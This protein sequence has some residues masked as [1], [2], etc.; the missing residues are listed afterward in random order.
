MPFANIR[1]SK[2]SQVLHGW[3]IHLIPYEMT[4][5]EFFVKFVLTK[6]LSPECGINIAASEVI[7]R[8]KLSETPVSTATQISPKCGKSNRKQTLRGDL[9]NW[10][11]LH[12]GGWST[13]SLADTQEKQFIVSLVETIWC[14]DM[15]NHEKLK[16]PLAPY[17]TSS[18]ML[19]S[20]FDWLRDAFDRFIIVIS[21]YV[22]FL[23]RQCDITAKNHASKNPMRSIDKAV[24][25]KIHK[26]NIWVAPVDKTKYNH[27]KNLLIDLPS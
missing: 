12:N 9:I 4:I 6:K 23:Q 11:H 1:I 17:A 27:L 2:G 18:W 24:T 13:Q 14:I 10:V 15:C 3:Y 7:E 8:V 21:S 19:R 22:G 16:E 5:K 25:V 26:K 20:N